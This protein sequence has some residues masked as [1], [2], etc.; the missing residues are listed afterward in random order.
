MRIQGLKKNI[1]QMKQKRKNFLRDIVSCS[2]SMG[3]IFTTM[4]LSLKSN[5]YFKTVSE[6]IDLET[7]IFKNIFQKTSEIIFSRRIKNNLIFY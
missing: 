3:I 1:G 2:Q 7:V 6:S 4:F 5:L